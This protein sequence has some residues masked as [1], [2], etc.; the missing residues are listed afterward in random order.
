MNALLPKTKRT[1][2]RSAIGTPKEWFAGATQTSRVKEQQQTTMIPM[3][4]QIVEKPASRIPGHE[5]MC[6]AESCRFRPHATSAK[7]IRRASCLVQVH[8]ESRG[9]HCD[10]ESSKNKRTPSCE[11]AAPQRHRHAKFPAQAIATQTHPQ[12]PRKQFSSHS[13]TTLPPNSKP[14]NQNATI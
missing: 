3:V 2:A 8:F 13:R 11:I 9:R 6:L 5:C 7:T 14:P 12:V 10:Q 4:S 1:T